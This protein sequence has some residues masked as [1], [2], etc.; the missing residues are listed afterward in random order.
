MPDVRAYSRGDGTRVSAH[1]RGDPHRTGTFYRLGGP[2]VSAEG[3]A[4]VH[5]ERDDFCH[6]TKCPEC[7]A[8]V[9]FIRHNGGSVFVEQLGP[10]WRKHPC[11]SRPSGRQAH[12]EV[13]TPIAD[14]WFLSRLQR[15]ALNREP[16][17]LGVLTE[18]EEQTNAHGRLWRVLMQDGGTLLVT[19]PEQWTSKDLLGELVMLIPGR[20]QLRVLGQD[21]PIPY[22]AANDVG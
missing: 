1:S 10:P 3:W 2:S 13:H 7:R 4:R 20:R 14:L 8:D 5:V 15:A 11:T 17:A 6:P 21:I 19:L 22:S 18:A 9:Y 12:A 16:C